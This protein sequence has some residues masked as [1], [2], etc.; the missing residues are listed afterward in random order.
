MTQDTFAACSRLS[1]RKCGYSPCGLT[2]A[3]CSKATCLNTLHEVVSVDLA[4]CCVEPFNFA[5][6]APLVT[7]SAKYGA[8]TQGHDLIGLLGE[9]LR[10][11]TFRSNNKWHSVCK[12]PVVLVFAV[13]KTPSLAGRV[14]HRHP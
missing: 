6:L 3:Q 1:H 11:Y 9:D 10:L 4:D 5:S 12:L 8:W 2:C 14:G 7:G 13:T